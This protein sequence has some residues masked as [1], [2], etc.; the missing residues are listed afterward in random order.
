[1]MG[2]IVYVNIFL[3]YLQEDK[4]QQTSKFTRAPLLKD[5]KFVYT[6]STSFVSKKMVTP[7]GVCFGLHYHVVLLFAFQ[8]KKGKL[9]LDVKQNTTVS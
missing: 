1:M 4:Q 5:A 7:C 2:K 6:V 3:F 8:L 9:T